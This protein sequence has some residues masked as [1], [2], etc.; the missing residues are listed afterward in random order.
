MEAREIE[1][2]LFVLIQTVRTP[3]PPVTKGKKNSSSPVSAVDSFATQS[4]S[5][6]VQEGVY[7]LSVVRLADVTHAEM[8]ELNVTEGNSTYAVRLPSAAILVSIS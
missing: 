5:T 6:V 8:A 4:G 2:W 3:P 1:A 7:A